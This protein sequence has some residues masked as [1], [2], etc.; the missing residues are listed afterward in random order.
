MAAPAPTPGPNPHAQVPGA[1]FKQQHRLSRMEALC[2]ALAPNAA[3]ADTLS[4]LGLGDA[5]P[6]ATA[7]LAAACGGGCGGTQPSSSGSGVA[8]L[9]YVTLLNQVVQMGTQLYHDAVVPHHHK[10][11]AHQ[12]ALLYVSGGGGGQAQGGVGEE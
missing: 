8:H 4:T 3:P 1:A 2:R 12:I 6:F 7:R 10:Y 5:Y 9:Q 11:A